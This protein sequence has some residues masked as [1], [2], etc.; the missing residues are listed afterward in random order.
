MSTRL[1]SLLLVGGCCFF[2]CERADRLLLGEWEATHITEGAD[3][4]AV[5]PRQIGFVFTP[6]NRYHFRSTL[7]YREAGT[8]RYDNGYLFAR[9]T[10][11]PGQPERIVAV[12]KMTPDSL[13]IRM[14][15]DSAERLL[16]LLR[17]SPRPE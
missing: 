15:R 1:F 17:T 4:L 5:D 2:G 11:Q 13:V 14:Q 6:D 10:T 8:W 12:E 9:D 7:K 16:T 3:T